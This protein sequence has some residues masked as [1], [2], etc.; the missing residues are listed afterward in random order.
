MCPVV[1]FLGH[2]VDL[3]LVSKGFSILFSRMAVSVYIPTNRVGM[4]EGSLFS[5]SSQHLLFIDF[6]MKAILT[7]VR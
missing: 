1:E 4:Y 5:T 2:I 3:F 7:G 6:L